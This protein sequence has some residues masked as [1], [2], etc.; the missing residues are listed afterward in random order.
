MPG[1]RTSPRGGGVRFVIAC[2]DPAI[3]QGK[4]YA[5]NEAI[6]AIILSS[7]SERYQKVAK[8]I[9]LVSERAAKGTRFEAIAE[10]VRGLVAEG[11]LQGAGDL[12]RWTRTVKCE[13]RISRH[14]G[15]R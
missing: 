5:M 11:K 14:S 7:A 2:L 6:D 9:S 4:A 12:T 8:V 1:R 3:R 13:S 15:A 10:R